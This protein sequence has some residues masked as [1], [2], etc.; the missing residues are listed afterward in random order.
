MNP[1][2]FFGVE[3]LD[4]SAGHTGA[5]RLISGSAL[6]G[7]GDALNRSAQQGARAGAR[8]GAASHDIWEVTLHGNVSHHQRVT[9]RCTCPARST[10]KGSGSRSAGP[11]TVRR[12]QPARHAKPRL[13]LC[14]QQADVG[15]PR[16]ARAVGSPRALPVRPWSLTISSRPTD[17]PRYRWDRRCH[18]R[19]STRPATEARVKTGRPPQL[20]EETCGFGDYKST[21]GSESDRIRPKLYE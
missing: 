21:P 3:P 7:P 17:G 14:R 16:M 13:T 11:Q 19:M 6:R 18:Q 15:I 9:V 20:T 5:F 2:P 12:T 4:G 1:K 8:A 10:Q